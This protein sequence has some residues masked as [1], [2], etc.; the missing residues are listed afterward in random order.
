[1]NAFQIKVCGI[2]RAKDALLAAKLG[3]DM[4]GFIF[5]EGSPRYITPS[6]AKV[7]SR[8]VAPTVDLVGVFVDEKPE[9]I[10]R[11]AKLVGLN[12]VQYHG[13]LK[14]I[15]IQRFH[16]SGL[17]V[18]QSF[19]VR[20]QSDYAT[21]LKSKADIVHLD[22]SAPGMA[23]GTGRRFDWSIKPARRIKKLMLAGG[24]DA[25]NVVEGVRQ[26]KPLAV[27]VNSGVES[28]PGMKSPTMLKRFFNA[29]NKARYD[30]TI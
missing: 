15:D 25:D 14:T 3:A 8:Q 17:K 19:A 16:K 27:D 12:W 22:N 11:I 24:I 4:L 21:V 28:R 26:F 2:T 13:R 29:C 7:V 20:Q 23:G 10:L 1:M 5:Y 18:I 6:N 9:K 30:T